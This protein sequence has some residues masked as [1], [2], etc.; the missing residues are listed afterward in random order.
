LLFGVPLYRNLTAGHKRFN[1]TTVR[2][3]DSCGGEDQ[4]RATDLIVIP[5]II[6]R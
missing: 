1:N 2:S 5:K 4:V 3:E 6:S